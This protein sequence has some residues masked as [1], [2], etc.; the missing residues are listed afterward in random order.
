MY[1]RRR[2]VENYLLVWMDDN[3][4]RND[5]DRKSILVQLETVAND[6]YIF[7]Q[8]DECID[9]LTDIRGIKMFLLLTGTMGQQI[10]PLIHDIS[11][12]D[13]V[14]I[15]CDNKQQHEIWAKNWTKIIAVHTSIKSIC[16]SLQMGVKQLQH[17]DV[18]ISVISANERGSG[19]NL[20]QLEAS[21]MY[22]QILKEILLDMK[23]DG[24][25]KKAFIKFLRNEYL[26]NGSK[27][28]DIDRFE[29]EYRPESSI[30]WYS[31]ES[32]VYE[33]LNSALRTL[34]SDVIIRMG[35]LLSDIHRQIEALHKKQ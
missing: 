33:A 19:E 4:D 34:Q 29:H 1:E 20:N 25:V 31:R 6:V 11:S 32:Y 30:W 3:I 16:E 12:L 18:S 23:Y 15:F 2:M 27:L 22:S 21:F 13:S 26:N 17:N 14:Y 9:F 35:F 10:I 24:E 7:I 5:D 8:R 28:K